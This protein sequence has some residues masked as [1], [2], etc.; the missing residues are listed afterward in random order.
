MDRYGL[1]AI[2]HYREDTPPHWEDIWILIGRK[3][4]LRLLFHQE[5]GKIQ[6]RNFKKRLREIGIGKGA[7]A[8]LEGMI[9]ASGVTKEEAQKAVKSIVPSEKRAWVHIFQVGK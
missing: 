6:S 1:T 4:A 2:V 7:Y 8:I 5:M 3:P 9:V